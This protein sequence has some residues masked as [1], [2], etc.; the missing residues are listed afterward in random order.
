MGC[1]SVTLKTK[2]DIPVVS[3]VFEVIGSEG[4]DYW[5]IAAGYI[6]LFKT[7]S[8]PKRQSCFCCFFAGVIEFESK[9]PMI[10]NNWM[11]QK[12]NQHV[13]ACMI[14]LSDFGRKNI[15]YCS[16]WSISCHDPSFFGGRGLFKL[17]GP[18]SPFCEAVFWRLS[19]QDDRGDV[20]L[21]SWVF[22]QSSHILTW[23]IDQHTLHIQTTE[24]RY[25]WTPKSISTKHLPLT[26]LWV[27]LLDV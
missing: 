15:V 6:I 26:L 20:G 3:S 7:S 17:P 16:C 11:V 1:N 18:R 2:P 19:K 21:L 24:V 25:V 23:H 22:G 9:W 13:T 8:S 27:F 4:H 5:S 14:F 10:D 12:Q